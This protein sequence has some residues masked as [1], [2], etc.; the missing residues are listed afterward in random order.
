M[1]KLKL[2]GTGPIKYHLG[3]DFA[4]DEYGTLCFAPRKYIEKMADAYFSYFGHKPKTICTS[5]L[6]QGDYPELDS[7]TRMEFNNL[8]L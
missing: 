2:K 5:P 3:C 8:S 7:S 4:R 6:E 1:H